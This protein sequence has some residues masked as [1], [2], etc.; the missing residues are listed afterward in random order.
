M[1]ERPSV[2]AWALHINGELDEREVVETCPFL[3]SPT[4][5]NPDGSGIKLRISPTH[6]TDWL[7]ASSYT[8][9]I[10]TP[11]KDEQIKTPVKGERY[12]WMGVTLSVLRVAE[13]AR[14]P[15][16]A[17]SA[18]GSRPGASASRS[19]RASLHSGKGSRH[20]SYS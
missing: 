5:A 10:K 8:Y 12:R 20:T 19:P 6:V 3:F 18:P 7:P 13:T 14:G 11:T 1:S 2:G 16:S 9:T 15:I 4:K 17:A